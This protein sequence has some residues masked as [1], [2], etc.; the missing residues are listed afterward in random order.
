MKTCTVFFCLIFFALGMRAQSTWTNYSLS[1]TPS[2]TVAA[3]DAIE[4]NASETWLASGAGVR[5]KGTAG[6]TSTILTGMNTI[7]FAKNRAN[8]WVAAPA[9][10]VYVYPNGIRT[11]SP[12]FY[13]LNNIGISNITC[14]EEFANRI[15]VGGS[16][17]LAYI[18]VFSNGIPA[19]GTVWT[20]VPGITDVQVCR[21]GQ[22]ELY[23]GTG[24]GLHKW[25][26][27]GITPVTVPQM[28]AGT[29]INDIYITAEQHI[30][31]ATSQGLYDTDLANTKI[32]GTHNGLNTNTI[33]SVGMDAYGNTWA[34]TM[35]GLFRYNGSSWAASSLYQVNRME[36][37]LFIKNISGINWF[38]TTNKAASLD[39]AYNQNLVVNGSFEHPMPAFPAARCYDFAFSPVSDE[40][41]AVGSAQNYIRGWY[42]KN[43][44]GLPFTRT[45]KV[46]LLHK[47]AHT[48]PRSPNDPLG[49]SSHCGF[50]I[51]NNTFGSLVYTH[52]PL[53][54]AYIALGGGTGI[55]GELKQRLTAR[56]YELNIM[57]TY[58]NCQ[59]NNNQPLSG[60]MQLEISFG[61][62]N[63]NM[64]FVQVYT[65]GRLMNIAATQNGNFWR[66]GSLPINLTGVSQAAQIT[67]IKMVNRTSLGS[68]DII[69]LDQ[70]ALR[71]KPTQLTGY[72]AF[73]EMVRFNCADSAFI[74]PDA[75]GMGNTYIWTENNTTVG[76]NRQLWV[77]VPAGQTR[78]LTLSVINLD[79]AGNDVPI[80]T[81]TYYVS[82]T[83]MQVSIIP[84]TGANNTVSAL[85]ARVTG[86]SGQYSYEW[87][88]P[89][90]WGTV[91]TGEF[92]GNL[93]CVGAYVLTVKDNFTGCTKTVD[94]NFNAPGYANCTTKPVLR[95][96]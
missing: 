96:E 45:N 79:V 41:S 29:V 84:V 89:G 64:Q 46:F 67:H 48:N 18:D 1:P 44:L 50:G 2:L 3:N 65:P 81:Y 52:R 72:T 62:L 88:R 69:F 6:I 35:G 10:G 55:V 49:C 57:G 12:T 92:P 95:R 94:Y 4:A 5:I 87:T 11:N 14:I 47:K 40:F 56:N 53:D 85:S 15:W 33:L 32:Y 31:M 22:N 39:D 75:D 80:A 63:T 90:G 71:E 43:V 70:L 51:P 93:L 76:N 36:S 54:A 91:T 26:G 7:G 61:Y 20:I 38:G 78:T 8:I 68:R 82:R 74:G 30:L 34:G 58:Y 27:P 24:N 66:T 28:N 9:M 16:N 23:I 60:N 77:G 83:G 37:V 25:D 13:P 59:L 21:A 42:G 86:G 73:T 19:Q 17:G